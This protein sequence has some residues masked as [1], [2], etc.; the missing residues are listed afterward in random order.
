[1][2]NAV[3]Q[4]MIVHLMIT[5]ID[6][7][8]EFIISITNFVHSDDNYLFTVFTFRVFLGLPLKRGW[9]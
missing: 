9:C 3:I 1:M 5:I 7:I 4:F 6:F 8:M 2:L